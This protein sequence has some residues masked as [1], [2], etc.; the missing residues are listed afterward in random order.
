MTTVSGAIVVP[1]F[2]QHLVGNALAGEA[3][4]SGKKEETVVT[5]PQSSKAPKAGRKSLTEFP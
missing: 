5:T 4:I 1:E 2:L 3:A